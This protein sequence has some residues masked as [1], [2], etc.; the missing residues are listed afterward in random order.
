MHDDFGVPDRMLGEHPDWFCPALG[1][2]VAVCALLETRAQ[3]L[4]ENLA[5]MEP[6]TL[7]RSRV[8]SWATLRQPQSR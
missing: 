1:R 6:G 5:R 3:S 4:A 8:T 7:T 2:V